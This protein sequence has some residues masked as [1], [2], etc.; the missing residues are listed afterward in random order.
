MYVLV[1]TFNRVSRDHQILVFVFSLFYP[2][3]NQTNIVSL[4]FRLTDKNNPVISPRVSNLYHTAIWFDFGA[5]YKQNLSEPGVNRCEFFVY[6]TLGDF[7]PI[8]KR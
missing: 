4:V 8:P 6:L 2:R 7:L 5:V 1:D 3:L